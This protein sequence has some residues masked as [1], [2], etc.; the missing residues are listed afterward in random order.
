MFV[1]FH[2]C[3]TDDHLCTIVL[4]CLLIVLTSVPLMFPG[5]HLKN[6][7]SDLCI[8]SVKILNNIKKGWPVNFPIQILGDFRRI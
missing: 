5:V 8:T 1:Q 7:Y 6:C 3:C 2:S 4:T